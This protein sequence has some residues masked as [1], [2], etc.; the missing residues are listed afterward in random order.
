[1]VIPSVF[2]ESDPKMHMSINLDTGLWRC[3]KTGEKGNFYQLYSI[4]EK[5]TYNKARSKATLHSY[6]QKG[7]KEAKRAEL[8]KKNEDEHSP[9]EDLKN[10]IGI[11]HD[12]HL[13]WDDL[14]EFHKECY[15]YLNGRRLL[16]PDKE[17]PQF[18]FVPPEANDRLRG[19]III[20]YFEEGQIF[21]YQARAMGERFPKYLNSK[22]C[23]ASH[24]LYPFNELEEYVIVAEGPFDCISLQLAGLNATC[25]NGSYLSKEQYKLL[26]E[27]GCDVILGFDAD[28]AGR[29]GTLNFDKNR[30]KYM[31]PPFQ[32]CSPPTGYSDWNEAFMSHRDLAKW[33]DN[34]TKKFNPII[35]KLDH[36]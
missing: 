5:C 16:D 19:R 1:M 36:L 7:K 30:R 18:Y 25:T 31:I 23:K 4:L 8:L 26:G 29:E 10:A 3:F 17:G 15:N 20:P 33:V 14:S 13:G 22:T 11:Q 9:D 27:S 35:F 32:V 21:F 28:K 2:L 12:D 34:N 6:T 24:V